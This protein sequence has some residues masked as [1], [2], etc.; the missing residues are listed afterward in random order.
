MK[1]A[2]QIQPSNSSWGFNPVIVKKK[3]GSPR[4]CID[5]RPLNEVTKKDS[6]PL[7]RTDEVLNELGKAKWFSKLDLKAG[8]WQIML[9]PG[10]RHKTAF[11]TRDGLFEFLVMPFGLTSAPATFQR[12]MDTVL[13]DLLWHRVMVYL[14]DIIVYSETWHE[15]LA[16]LG[17]VLRR[18][19]AAGLQA[20]PGKCEFGRATL[21]YLGHIVTREGILPD[22]D[23]VKA[24]MQ[25]PAP[26]NLTELRS[27][28]GMVQYY[29]KYIPH[30][31]QLYVPLYRLYKKNA[32]F[33]WTHE[34]Q[35]AFEE[36]KAALISPPVLRRADPALPYILQTDWSPTA[37]GAILA[38]EDA[39]G[40]EHPIAYAS[41]SLKDLE[42]KYSATE[43]ECFAVVS[44]VEHFRPYLWGVPFTLEVDH[45]CLQW[46][47]TASQNNSRLARWAL[48]L[49][50][51]DFKIRHRRGTRHSN[52]D[53]L[54][55]PPIACPAEDL[56]V[57]TLT[58]FGSEEDADYIAYGAVGPTHFEGGSD[59]GPSVLE[60]LPCEVCGS[61]EHADIML[62]CDNCNKGTHTTCLKPPLPAVPTGTW[63]CPS[64]DKDADTSPEQIPEMIDLTTPRLDITQDLPTLQYIKT[65]TFPASG[66]EQEKMR[67]R[68]KSIRYYYRGEQLYHRVADK[69]VPDIA[70]R[71]EIIAKA[72]SYGR[73]GIDKTPTLCRTTTGGGA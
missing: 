62:L 26:R 51:Y 37:I 58:A 72:H 17:N 66:S 73:Y 67:I 24:I 60:E 19:R 4:V 55:R 36:V 14:D 2:G 15:H 45:W 57:F 7:P 43:G 22:N 11:V 53:A 39:D 25:C 41:K 27:F 6:Y 49:Q 8:Y 61:P 13:S 33:Y 40:E 12:L 9:N 59:S 54:S 20:S 65:N 47:M 70:D 56:C 42:R 23:N 10:D 16:T 35:Q 28:T 5:Y 64:C 3:D 32:P 46:L 69:P 30:M 48:K 18:L 34:C 68:N 21:Q 71:P 31:A 50:E 63:I 1:A 52:A 38:Q 29:N 44:F